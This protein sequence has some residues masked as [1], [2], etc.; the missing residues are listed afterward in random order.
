LNKC[1][2]SQLLP[3]I[4]TFFITIVSL[5]ST[6]TKTHIQNAKKRLKTMLRHPEKR[7]NIKALAAHFHLIE[8]KGMEGTGCNSGCFDDS[9]DDDDDEEGYDSEHERL[10]FS[11][12]QSYS[13]ESGSG[14][15][16][17]GNE[18]HPKVSSGSVGHHEAAV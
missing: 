7:A 8:E 11:L 15:H 5:Q 9:D 16:G 4:K 13:S 17:G 14:Y 2:V 10:G 18:Y 6:Y 12:G 3:C 1:C